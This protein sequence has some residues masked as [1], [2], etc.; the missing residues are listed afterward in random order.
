MLT[1]CLLVLLLMD[2]MIHFLL[3]S[4]RTVP[5]GPHP[6][7]VPMPGLGGWMPWG[8]WFSAIG[9][10]GFPESGANFLSQFPVKDE[11]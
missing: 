11:V 9:G 10:G 1:G 4:N 3:A 6:Y 8:G 7:P 2:D 5:I